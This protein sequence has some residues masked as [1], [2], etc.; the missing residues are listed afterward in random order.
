MFVKHVR[1]P[2][3]LLNIILC[4]GSSPS[5]FISIQLGATSNDPVADDN[6]WYEFSF[7]SILHAILL[8]QSLSLIILICLFILF[9]TLI[10]LVCFIFVVHF[11]LPS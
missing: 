6:F 4:C 5:V 8:W 3:V 1:E 7:P 11:T 10:F 9:S 2:M